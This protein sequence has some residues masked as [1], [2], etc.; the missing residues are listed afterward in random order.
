[1]GVKHSGQSIDDAHHEPEAILED[2]LLKHELGKGYMYAAPPGVL[3]NYCK[4]DVTETVNVFL[5][6]WEKVQEPMHW[7]PYSMLELAMG[8][9]LT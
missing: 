4:H 6:L 8:E 1:M 7:E 3:E 2:W 5:A 9:P